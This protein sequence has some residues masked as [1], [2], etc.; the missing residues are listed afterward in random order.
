MSAYQPQAPCRNAL[1][2]SEPRNGPRSRPFGPPS[3]ISDSM[4]V[5]TISGITTSQILP[6]V[7]PVRG[8]RG[9][10]SQS[11]S[12]TVDQRKV[13][14]SRQTRVATSTNCQ[15]RPTV[16]QTF[17]ALKNGML[18]VPANWSFKAGATSQARAAIGSAAAAHTAKIARSPYCGIA[19]SETG[20]SVSEVAIPQYGLRSEEYMSVLQSRGHLVCIILLEKKNYLFIL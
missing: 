2:A 3:G 9:E 19:T 7:R 13:R 11:A 4:S 14:C 1:P 17:S 15:T 12:R 16:R 6:P 5:A 18:P 10:R 20:A 8:L